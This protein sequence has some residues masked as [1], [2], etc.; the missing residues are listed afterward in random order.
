MCGVERR[1]EPETIL[2]PF[3]YVQLHGSSHY[4]AIAIQAE[5]Q[6]VCLAVVGVIDGTDTLVRRLEK[7]ADSKHSSTS[8]LSPCE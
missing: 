1:E 7:P 2:M 6:G 8:C 3:S 4:I 5:I